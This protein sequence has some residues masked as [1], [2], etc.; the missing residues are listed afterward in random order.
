LLLLL[1][2]LLLLQ[3]MN[4]RGSSFIKGS[5]CSIMIIVNLP[6]GQILLRSYAVHRQHLKM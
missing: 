2:L 4:R 5:F 3:M 6:L 1:L